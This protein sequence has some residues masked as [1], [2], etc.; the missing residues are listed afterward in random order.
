MAHLQENGDSE[1]VILN[2]STGFPVVAVRVCLYVCMRM[3]VCACICM[4]VYMYSKLDTF[5]GFPVVTVCV[6]VVMYVCMYV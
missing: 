6:W 2:T 4:C 5:T 1:K 3:N